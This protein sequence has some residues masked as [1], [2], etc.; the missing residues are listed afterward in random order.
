MN[1]HKRPCGSTE[2]LWEKL[3]RS[4]AQPRA[5]IVQLTHF[6]VEYG[7]PDVGMECESE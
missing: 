7:F 5:T 3:K 1:T 2:P 4:V 6:L